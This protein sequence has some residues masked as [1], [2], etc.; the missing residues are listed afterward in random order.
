MDA[1][2]IITTALGV[3]I[4]GLM[5]YIIKLQKQKQ[6]NGISNAVELRAFELELRSVFDKELSQTKLNYENTISKI[7]L[8]FEKQLS[9]LKDDFR[10][11]KQN[12][13]DRGYEN[14]LK[15]SNVSVQIMPY[16]EITKDDGFFFKEEI[17]LIGY[18]YQLMSNGLPCLQSHIEIT[19]QLY[20]KD[21]KEEK[22]YQVVDTLQ[23]I[24]SMIPNPSIKMAGSLKE[25]GKELLRLKKS[26]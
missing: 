19:E 21:I 14:G 11:Q 6:N 1:T 7:K 18:K 17:V 20:L 10:R 15:A 4:L 13:Y 22:I 9:I 24:I 8:D 2:L 26:D 3:T 16:K 5:F 12:E 23:S 25:F